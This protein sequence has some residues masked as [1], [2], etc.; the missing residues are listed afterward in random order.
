LLSQQ[1]GAGGGFNSGKIKDVIK[2]YQAQVNQIATSLISNTTELTAAATGNVAGFGDEYRVNA[3]KEEKQLLER[4]EKLNKSY[5]DRV[6]ELSKA[7]PEEV[8]KSLEALTSMTDALNQG[9]REET[10]R[11]LAV[12][13]N[14]STALDNKLRSE[15]AQS[16]AKF[17]ESTQSAIRQYQS[18]VEAEAQATEDRSMGLGDQFLQRA[19]EATARYD[20][21]ATQSPEFLAEATRA[22]DTLSKAALSTRMDLLATADPRALEL[23][24]IADENAAAMM[25]GRIAADVQANVARSSAMR[26]LQGG[27]GASSEMGRGLT[28][29]DLGLT[30]LDLQQR[31]AALNDAQRRLNYETRVAGTQ[32]NPFDTAAQMQ[33]AEGVLLNTT[34]GTAESDRNQRLSA[35]QNASSQ[36]LGTMDA[37]FGTRLQAADTRRTQE[38]GVAQ[39][40]YSSNLDVTRDIMR[41]SLANT[42]DIYNNNLGLANTVFNARVGTAEG[43]LQAGLGLATDL[44][45]TNTGA[46]GNIYNTS[47]G[48]EGNIYSGRVTTENN[49]MSTNAAA[50]IAAA[51]ME[52]QAAGGAAATLSNIPIQQMQMQ[53]GNNAAS[54]ALWGSAI[55]SGSALAGSYL[56]SQN[57]N[58]NTNR[59]YGAGLMSTGGYN[60]AGAASSAA[61]YSS[62]VSNV[63]GVGYVPRATAT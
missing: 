23:S 63:S 31:G 49:A 6:A 45:K 1:G 17:D 10:L 38:M 12:F 26:A 43:L 3:K 47:V 54:A 46:V 27:F 13:E 59:S 2:D 22:A 11:Q 29:R 28:A 21:V 7:F 58:T 48:M 37:V 4:L 35:I 18:D 39:N 19:S 60:S 62:S 53:M 32:V 40:M 61:R 50:Q 9:S 44:Y 5:S 56:G 41:T 20:K 15:S 33:Q 14:A 25:S 55:Q 16:L 42:Y 57:W 30:S 34:I 51:Q 24:A 52:A 8:G 36:R